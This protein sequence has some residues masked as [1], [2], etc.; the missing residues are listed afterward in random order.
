[1]MGEVRPKQ[2]ILSEKMALINFRI[3]GSSRK[4]KSIYRLAVFAEK[5]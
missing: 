2:V 4:Q 3:K 1:M 5:T